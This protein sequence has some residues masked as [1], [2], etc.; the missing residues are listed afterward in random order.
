M[1][2]ADDGEESGER[3]ARGRRLGPQVHVRSGRFGGGQGRGSP[4]THDA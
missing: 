2:A 1:Y 3:L 4:R